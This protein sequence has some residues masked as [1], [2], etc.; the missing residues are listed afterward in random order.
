M[1]S[2]EEMVDYLVKLIKDKESAFS[3]QS[4]RL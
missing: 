4:A 1:Q 3:E 2:D